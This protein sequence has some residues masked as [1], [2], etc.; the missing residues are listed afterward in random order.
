[1]TTSSMMILP[2][3]NTTSSPSQ[4]VG[5]GDSDA[6]RLRDGV[7]DGVRVGVGERVGERVGVGDGVGDG[8]PTFSSQPTGSETLAA[9]L[10]LRIP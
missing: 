5:D 6:P 8:L 9:A 4:A 2:L 1:M 7:R 10:S 3:G